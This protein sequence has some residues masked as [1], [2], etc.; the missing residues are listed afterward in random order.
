M[1][2]QLA[3]AT[4]ESFQ[5]MTNQI[6]E[7]IGQINKK[8]EAIAESLKETTAMIAGVAFLLVDKGVLTVEE[9]ER[10]REKVLKA[11]GLLPQVTMTPEQKAEF[12]E[13]C[14]KAPPAELKNE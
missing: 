5:V 4:A 2:A 10:E 1:D 3:A 7:L 8:N 9:I 11:M 13:L 12:L 14:R 6:N